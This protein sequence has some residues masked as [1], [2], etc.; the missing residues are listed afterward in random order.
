MKKKIQELEEQV[1]V[2]KEKW[3]RER[4][5]MVNYKKEE[6][7]RLKSLVDYTEQKLAEKF[8]PIVDSFEMAKNHLTEE[9]LKDPSVK[10]LIMTGKM[11]LDALGLEEIDYLNKKYDP[12]Y[13]EVAETVEG[14]DPD[15]VIATIQKG[16][17]KKD[18]IIRVNK[19]KIIK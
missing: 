13:C 7:E 1:Q 15:T 10:G 3:Q 17:K 14:D 18:K 9:Q 8:L 6:G 12:K 4:A 2:F 19:V 5:D 16:Y 11:L